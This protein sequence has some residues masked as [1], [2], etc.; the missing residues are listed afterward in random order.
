MIK[1]RAFAFLILVLFTGG[2]S[3]NKPAPKLVAKD[4]TKVINKMTELMVHDVTNP[5]LAARFFA[6]SC[7]AG[8]EVVSE[9][10]PELKDMY[11][12]LKQYPRIKNAGSF[13]GFDYR[14]SAL[15]AMLDAASKLQPSGKQLVAYV[16]ILADSCRQIGFSDAVIE[17]SEHYAQFIASKILA[18]A[19]TDKYNTT[20]IFPRYKETELPGAWKPTPPAF[21]SPIEPYFNRIRPMTLDSASQFKLNPPVPFSAQKNSAFFKYLLL[22][23]RKGA[24]NLTPEEQNIANFWDCN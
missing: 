10:N 12:K 19:K 22:N 7:L 14:L 15:F 13:S 2:C 18:Y 21:M 1:R 6:Y 8:Y 11:G 20:S 16:H 17:S 9:N 3:K 5:P 4:V 23:Y 24:D